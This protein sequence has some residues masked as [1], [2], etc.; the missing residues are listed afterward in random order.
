MLI[1]TQLQKKQSKERESSCC[2]Q[3]ENLI[4]NLDFY[5]NLNNLILLACVWGEKIISKQTRSLDQEEVKTSVITVI[6]FFFLLR[7]LFFFWDVMVNEL[8]P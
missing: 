1:L 4:H 8:I 5:N 6:N 3:F 7:F 2:S